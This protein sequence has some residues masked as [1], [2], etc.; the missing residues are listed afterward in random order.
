MY[1]RD[2]TRLTAGLLA[3]LALP[4]PALAQ[5]SLRVVISEGPSLENL[6]LLL[7]LQRLAKAGTSVDVTIVADE[8]AVFG[9]VTS[10]AADM[11][12]GTPYDAIRNQQA[13]L[14]VIGQ[15][16]RVAFVPVATAEYASVEALDGASVLLH[17]PGSATETMANRLERAFGIRL[18]ERKYLAGSENR[19]RALQNGEAAF[20][21]LDFS[22]YVSIE[23]ESPGRFRAF[24]LPEIEASDEV[25]FASQAALNSNREVI[26]AT[27]LALQSVW[28]DLETRPDVIEAELGATTLAG[29]LPADLVATLTDQVV[30]AMSFGMFPAANVEPTTIAQADLEWYLPGLS[31]APGSFWDFSVARTKG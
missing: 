3:G 27:V 17:A 20:T 30:D 16:T 28:K 26:A 7:A 9:A 1:R 4:M 6:P 10:G 13:P 5:G 18:G 15:S 23:L 25:V 8:D 29:D 14:R 31:V 11:G 2:F 22:N 24:P 19:R 12:V 21:L